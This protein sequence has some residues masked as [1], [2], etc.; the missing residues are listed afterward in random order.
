ML[1]KKLLTKSG[2]QTHIL[3]ILFACRHTLVAQNHQTNVRLHHCLIL[4]SIPLIKILQGFIRI[5]LE[6]VQ[7]LI[8]PSCKNQ[9][10]V[11][12]YL[13]R[14]LLRSYKKLKYFTGSYKKLVSSLQDLT[15][16]YDTDLVRS[17]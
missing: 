7:N 3:E 8:D 5:L 12:K 2:D 17:C 9:E 16:S 4:I 13:V 1:F 14:N 10:S 15:R 6:S 11:W